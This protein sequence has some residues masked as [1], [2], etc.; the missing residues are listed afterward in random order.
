MIHPD[1]AERI[2][3][4]DPDPWPCWVFAEPDGS[5]IEQGLLVQ[6]GRVATTL[7]WRVREG[8]GGILAV[9]P[10]MSGRDYH[11]LHHENPVFHFEAEVTDGRVVFR[12]Y[13][14]LP[15]IIACSNGAYT[16]QPDWYRNFL[17]TEERARGLD[18]VEDLASPGFFRFDL[19]QGEAVLTLAAEGHEP[20]EDVATLRAAEQRPATAVPDPSTPLGGR[21][22][23]PAGER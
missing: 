19:A 13:P 21:V 5:R 7:Y 18:H 4:F 11:A 8:R 23:R 9:R 17:Y 3:S 10:L 16:H 15:A 20:G 22:P 12:P 14:G 6:P 2:E 1:G